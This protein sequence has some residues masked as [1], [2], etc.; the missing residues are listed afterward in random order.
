MAHR[1]S[2]QEIVLG[3]HAVDMSWWWWWWL[4]VSFFLFCIYF[5][6]NILEAYKIT[7]YF[8]PRAGEDMSNPSGESQ[9]LNSQ[10]Y[11]LCL[12]TKFTSRLY[13]WFL[14]YS[15]WLNIFWSDLVNLHLFWLI[16]FGLVLWHINYFELFNAKSFLYI[17]IKHIWFVKTFC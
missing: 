6:K 4:Y 15:N 11:L 13:H 14:R 2:R 8:L 17:Y 16:W 9:F 7:R 1:D 5:W 3:F 10:K 12:V